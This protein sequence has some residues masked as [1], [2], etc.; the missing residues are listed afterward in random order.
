A[1]VAHGQEGRVVDDRRPPH[2]WGND[3]LRRGQGRLHLGPVALGQLVGR[4]GRQRPGD[5]LHVGEPRSGHVSDLLPRVE[6]VVAPAVAAVVEHPVAGPLG[7][8]GPHATAHLGVEGPSPP[9]HPGGTTAR[10]RAAAVLVLAGTDLARAG[11][12]RLLVTPA[13]GL[14]GGRWR[15]GGEVGGERGQ[16]GADGEGE[17]EGPGPRGVCGGHRGSPWASTTRPWS[18]STGRSTVVESERSSKLPL[19]SG[20][21]ELQ[22]TSQVTV[23]V[24]VQASGRP[25]TPVRRL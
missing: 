19:A 22:V 18:S 7:G 12:L 23:A 21:W 11:A 9:A 5:D 2:R 20:F 4:R 16:Q 17:A 6:D 15:W 14:G 24:A 8:V 3:Q 13:P 10:S 1:P 25:A